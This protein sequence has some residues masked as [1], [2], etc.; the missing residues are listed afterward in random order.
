MELLRFLEPRELRWRTRRKCKGSWKLGRI[1]EEPNEKPGTIW[2]KDLGN[3]YWEKSGKQHGG[4]WAMIVGR[5]YTDRKMNC[6]G[7]YKHGN[8][9]IVMVTKNIVI[10]TIKIVIIPN[11]YSNDY[12]NL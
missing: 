11:Q 10:F 2:E 12:N 8:R 5:I 4:I 6:N 1:W 3:I 9:F 7:Y